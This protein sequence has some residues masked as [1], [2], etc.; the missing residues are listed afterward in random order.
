VF[1]ALLNELLDTVIPNFERLPGMGRLFF[2]RPT[3]LVEA[4]NVISALKR[5]L[6][7]IAKEG[8]IQEY[9]MPHHLLL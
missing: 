7:D 1:D 8:E 9:V 4:I 3:R 2:G 5:K 6:R